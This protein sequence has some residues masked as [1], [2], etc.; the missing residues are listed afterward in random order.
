MKKYFTSFILSVIILLFLNGCSNTQA[1][2]SSK[3]EK[4]F[5]IRAINLGEKG[6][7]EEALDN[8]LGAYKINSKNILTVRNIGLVYCK[9]GEFEKGRKYFEEALRIDQYDSESLYN[10]SVIEY[11][12]GNYKKSLEILNRIPLERVNDRIIKALAYTYY[13]VGDFK[14]SKENFQTLIKKDM[15][16]DYSFY[17]SYMQVLESLNLNNEIYPFL[18]NVYKKSKEDVNI[19]FIFSDY[20]EKIEAYDEALNALKEFGV[21]YQFTQDITIRIANVYYLKNQP[22]EAEKFLN[23]LPENMMLDKRVL[24]LKQKI[25]K[26]QDRKEDE[27]AVRKILSKLKGNDQK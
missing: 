8:F 7:L 23:S 17:Y 4:Y 13:K 16:Q 10:L 12:G 9:L 5:I 27:E 3:D 18:Y 15:I 6:K 21:E 22:E 11:S 26:L 24:E 1:K 19:V 20:L 14:K 2:D 25:Y